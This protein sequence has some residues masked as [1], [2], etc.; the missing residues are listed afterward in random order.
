MSF[1]GRGKPVAERD[2]FIDLIGIYK[3]HA[4][5]LA[6]FDPIKANRIF[7]SPADVIAEAVTARMCFNYVP[8]TK[9]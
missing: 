2:R 5:T 9:K 4:L 3:Y 6:D 8:D 7:D 1:P